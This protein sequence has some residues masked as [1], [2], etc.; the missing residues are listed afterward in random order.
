MAVFYVILDVTMVLTQH[1]SGVA[2]LAHLAGAG[3][4]AL[5]FTM[6]WRILPTSNRKQQSGGLLK[7]LTRS[8][9]KSNANVRL[10]EPPAKELDREVDRILD[11]MNREGKDSLTSDEE[12]VLMRASEK[13]QKS[14]NV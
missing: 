13:Y 14:R 3:F 11:K 7:K 12:H 9:P 4:G 8:K 5:Y 6:G 2:H 10:Y 1:D